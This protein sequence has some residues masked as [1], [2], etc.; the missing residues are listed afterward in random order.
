M[1]SDIHLDVFIINNYEEEIKIFNEE[2]SREKQTELYKF[3]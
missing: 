3:I 2:S 1:N